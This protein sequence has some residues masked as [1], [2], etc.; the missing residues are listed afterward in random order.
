MIAGCGAGWKP[1]VAGA[2]DRRG[3]GN[4]LAVAG[5]YVGVDC[6]ACRDAVSARMDGEAEPVP[7]EV[8][9]AHLLVCA[10]CRSWGELAAEVTR[11]VLMRAMVPV[12][13]LADRI[14]AAV[15]RLR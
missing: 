5:D 13:D 7:A 3:R 11:A 15:A 10:A 8:T 12:P 4:F 6:L 1:G 14:L 2:G 9:D